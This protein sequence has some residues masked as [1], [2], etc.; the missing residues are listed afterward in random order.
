MKSQDHD[1]YWIK[2]AEAASAVN[3]EP[4]DEIRLWEL[5]K[6]CAEYVKKRLG[7]KEL[8]LTA[9]KEIYNLQDRSVLIYFLQNVSDSEIIRIIFEIDDTENADIGDPVGIELASN[10]NSPK[11]V[12]ESLSNIEYDEDYPEEQIRDALEAN[13]SARFLK[14]FN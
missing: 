12:L 10:I 11:D 5:S 3:G 7:K 1:E 8:I 9:F 4:K 2:L 14:R 13:P 6:K